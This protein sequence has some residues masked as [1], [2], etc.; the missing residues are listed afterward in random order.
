M[1]YH[2][3]D[4]YDKF[5]SLY[6]E[7]EKEIE[8]D[9]SWESEHGRLTALVSADL[10]ALFA[11]APGDVVKTHVVKEDMTYKILILSLG[12]CENLVLH[13]VLPKAG[14]GRTLCLEQP[15]R[16]KEA[17]NVE[18]INSWVNMERIFG[19]TLAEKNTIYH[20][21]KRWPIPGCFCFG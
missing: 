4:P 13:R 7:C 6:D 5:L 10:H 17:I 11:V 1:D 18:S 19:A 9:P 21:M 14:H 2:G 12:F 3:F 20:K 16:W 8:F 15:D